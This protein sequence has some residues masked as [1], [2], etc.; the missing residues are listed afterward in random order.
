MRRA[1]GSPQGIPNLEN[2]FQTQLQHAGTMGRA[3]VQEVTGRYALC[4]SRRIGRTAIAVE[5]IIDASPLRVVEDV[6]G[7]GAEFQL[8]SLGNGEVL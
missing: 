4:I 2:E 3:R 6:E 8:P 1:S 7:L 5:S